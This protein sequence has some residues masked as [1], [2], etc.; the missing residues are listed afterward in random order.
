[1]KIDEKLILDI[2]NLKKQLFGKDKIKLSKYQELIPM[3]DIYSQDIYPIHKKDIYY[4]L[5]E[6]HYRFINFEIF[7]WLKNLNIKYKD[8][9]DLS[10]KFKRNLDIIE[11]YNINTLIETSYKTFYEYSP[12]YGLLVSICKRNSFDPLMNHLKPYYTKLELI[13]LGKNM[14]L[15]EFQNNIDQ[16]KLIDKDVH[17][18]ICKIVS[19]NDISYEEIKNHS[20]QIVTAN[21]ISWITFYSFTGSFLFNKILRNNLKISS[22]LYDGLIAISK[23]IKDSYALKNDYYVYRFLSDDLF[24]K[25]INV[26]DYFIDNGFLSTT[27]DPFYSPGL[28]GTFGLILIKIHLPKNT[29]GIGLFIENFSLFPL[30]QEFLLPPCSKFKILSKDDNFK[31][32]HTNSSFEDIIHTKYELKYISTNYNFINKIKINNNTRLIDDLKLYQSHGA[33]KILIIK[34]FI[35]NYDQ[36]NVKLNNKFYLFQYMWFDSTSQS[37]YSKLYY[38]K[39]KDGVL[40]SLY[41]NGYPYL[42]IELGNELVINYLNM[43]YFCNNNISLNNELLELIVEF[44]RIFNYKEAKI[45][46]EYKNF[47]K[48]KTNYNKSDIFYLYNYMYNNTIYE[49]AKFKNKYLEDL[50]IKYNL[51]WYNLDKFLKKI[52]TDELINKYKLKYK[53]IGENLIDIIENN[54]TI[55]NYF[56]KDLNELK[57]YTLIGNV[58][59]N[60]LKDNFVTLDI[61]SKLLSS[62]RTKNYNYNINFNIEDE[63]DDNFKL[64]F[65]QSIRRY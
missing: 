23:L 27:R 16:E 4:K 65:R 56:I 46:H 26:G 30:E 63:L 21:I 42:N 15:K 20:N 45:F 36:I 28:N 10:T 37:S 52:I 48:I 43:Y 22:F 38:N 51:G 62:K 1:M 5:I 3:Y 29:K 54:F 11:N 57:D 41:E 60:L 34:N 9:K 58:K 2:F 44:G 64:I 25:N 55:Y 31:Y 39:I 59:I 19:S 61:A 13:K 49:Y 33:N 17:Y 40:F 35:D 24:I 53:T 32:Y 50:H 7:D 18:E 47:S 8:N 14:Q 6:C 12:D